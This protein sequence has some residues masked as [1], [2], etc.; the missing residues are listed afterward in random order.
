[1]K[2]NETGRRGRKWNGKEEGEGNLMEKEEGKG[3]FFIFL[4]SISLNDG[5]TEKRKKK[6]KKKRV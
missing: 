1:M 3:F 5:N 2:W 6:P 4:P